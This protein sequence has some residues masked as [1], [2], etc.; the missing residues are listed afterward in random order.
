M[1][2][3]LLPFLHTGE[4]NGLRMRLLKAAVTAGPAE[5]LEMRAAANVLVTPAVWMS[6]ENALA[7]AE[8]K[9]LRGD[10]AIKRAKELVVGLGEGYNIL[11][12]YKRDKPYLLVWKKRTLGISVDYDNEEW[13]KA[14]F[15][16]FLKWKD[17]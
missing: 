14:A 16:V 2:L 13:K 17:L 1:F 9:G 7:K 4:A 15:A 3:L 10:D 5:A 11:Q 8:L 12:Y 6:E